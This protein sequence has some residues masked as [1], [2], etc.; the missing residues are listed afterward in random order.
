LPLERLFCTVGFLNVDEGLD[1]HW[2]EGSYFLYHLKGFRASFYDPGLRSVVL[3]IP[4][5]Q[6]FVSVLFDPRKRRLGS[7]PRSASSFPPAPVKQQHADPDFFSSPLGDSVG[8]PLP[9]ALYDAVLVL[10][11]PPPLLSLQFFFFSMD[12][13]NTIF[14][15]FR[16]T[17][18]GPPLADFPYLPPCPFNCAFL[19]ARS[20]ITSF[21]DKAI[22]TFSPPPPPT[23]S[24]FLFSSPVGWE[25][26][27]GLHP[28]AQPLRRIGPPIS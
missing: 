7:V 16:L 23:L 19:K 27:K 14:L 5:P 1:G 15:G 21:S 24:L 6:H 28:K 22:T 8:P 18:Q 12:L 25:G 13:S 2:T 10:H 4:L 3:H 9:R 17:F 11:D 20:A 26:S